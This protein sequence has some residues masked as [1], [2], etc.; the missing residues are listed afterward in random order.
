MLAVGAKRWKNKKSF[1][2]PEKAP[3]RQPHKEQEN[4]TLFLCNSTHTAHNNQTIDC[5]V[6]GPD[7][8]KFRKA[9]KYTYCIAEDMMLLF[10]VVGKDG[11]RKLI[12][13]LTIR[14]SVLPLIF[15]CYYRA[16]LFS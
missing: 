9:Q 11:F 4:I 12:E 7:E 14:E 8:K 13:V 16:L 15:F 6:L 10:T 1:P 3:S 5:V 2:S